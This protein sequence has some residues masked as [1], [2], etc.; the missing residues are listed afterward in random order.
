MGRG[1]LCAEG[2]VVGKSRG[3]ALTS[4]DSSLRFKPS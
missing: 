1:A 3:I 2:D 4:L